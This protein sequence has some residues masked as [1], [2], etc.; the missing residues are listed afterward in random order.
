MKAVA[1]TY[2]LALRTRVRSDHDRP[3][4]FDGKEGHP[5]HPYPPEYR[6]LDKQE[7]DGEAD[8]FRGV[9]AWMP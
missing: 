8:P 6:R 5:V 3:I 9:L 1:K 7:Q 2:E 4:A